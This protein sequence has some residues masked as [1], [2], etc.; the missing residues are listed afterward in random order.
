MKRL[1][2]ILVLALM[3][4]PAFSDTGGRNLASESLD[5]DN[6]IGERAHKIIFAGFAEGAE[7]LSSRA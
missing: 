6:S 7:R 4:A 3:T 2:C 1:L 5:T